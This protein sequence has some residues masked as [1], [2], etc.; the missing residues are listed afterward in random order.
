[1]HVGDAVAGGRYETFDYAEDGHSPMKHALF[2][3][4]RGDWISS[5][6][7]EYYPNGQ[8]AKIRQMLEDG[9]FDL[10]TYGEDS[11]LLM[12]RLS[13]SFS[14]HIVT[15][16]YEADG[17]TIKTKTD[18]SY[19][20]VSVMNYKNGKPTQ[21]NTF[22]FAYIVDITNVLMIT[23]YD[24]DGQRQYRQK[25]VIGW[26]KISKLESKL[27]KVVLTPSI[28]TLAE[29][30]YLNANMKVTKDIDLFDDHKTPRSIETHAKPENE[31]PYPRVTKSFR[32]DGTLEKLKEYN[33]TG[34]VIKVEKHTSED[35]IRE[36][37]DPDALEM[38]IWLELPDSLKRV[39]HERDD[40]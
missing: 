36:T 30:Q 24:A 37:V 5:L 20:S 40:R 12:H 34:E 39:T 13:D 33:E 22:R 29:V 27:S 1:M 16:L 38:H 23:M 4:V 31:R 11:H 35:N 14:T 7:Q 15:E 21:E 25:W 28:Y 10:R 2:V 8:L 18:E 17:Q 3:K 19:A 9:S 26:D 32:A 6:L